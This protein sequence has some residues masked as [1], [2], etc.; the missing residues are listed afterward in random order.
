MSADVE[1]RQKQRTVIEFLVAEGEI[2][3]NIHRRMKNVYGDD[4]IDYSNVKRWVNRLKDTGMV[5]KASVKDM[6]RSGRPSSAVNPVNSAKANAL[7]RADR[8]ITTDELALALNVSKGS[9]HNVVDSLGY[10]KVC[11]RWVPR[12]LSEDHKTARVDMC[13]QLLEHYQT[14]PTFLDRIITGD[15]TWVHHY[16]PE[17]KRTSMEW[18]HPTSPKTKKF[19]AEKS[20]GKV[21]ATI[22]WDSKGVILLDFLPRGETVNANVYIETLKK[23]KAR[24]RR[25]RPDSDM[26]NVLLQHDNARPHTSIKTR[27]M[28]TAFGWTTLPHPPYSP[29]LAPSDYHLFGPMKEALRGNRYSTDDEVKAAI[30][31][32]LR[33]QSAD[34]YNAG[35]HALLQRWTTAIQRGGDYVEK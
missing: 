11:A 26:C 24:I 33:E 14:D 35:I 15:E 6:P 1:V 28:V 16:E 21:M 27:E 20:A 34:F 23:L 25:V 18:R 19:K 13:T 9:A 31:G 3:I 22:F 30:K 10:S 29:D 2:P 32:W 7:I 4:T 5:G 17:S 12:Q 8:R